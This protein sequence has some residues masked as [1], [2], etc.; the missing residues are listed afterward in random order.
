MARRS[1]QINMSYV[2]DRSLGASKAINILMIQT[3]KTQFPDD[4]RSDQ[5]NIIKASEIFLAGIFCQL[6][7]ISLHKVHTKQMGTNKEPQLYNHI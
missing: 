4:N 3:F 2:T 6:N 1:D 5:I 7:R